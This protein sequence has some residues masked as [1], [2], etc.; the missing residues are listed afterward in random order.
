MFEFFSHVSK[1]LRRKHSAEKTLR[2]DA[3]VPGNDFLMCLVE[4]FA[5]L[6]YVLPFSRPPGIPIVYI[7]AAVPPYLVCYQ[8]R[9]VIK[10]IARVVNPKTFAVL[11]CGTTVSNF[12]PGAISSERSRLGA[13]ASSIICL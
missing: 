7:L 12:S 3:D 4:S 11:R 1:A 2:G 13:A 5:K 6:V 8:H 10:I 9:A